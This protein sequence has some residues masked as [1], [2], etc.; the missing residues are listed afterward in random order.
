MLFR[1]TIQAGIVG[2][3]E[4]P[5]LIAS[6]SP[7]F[8]VYTHDRPLFYHLLLSTFPLS[9]KQITHK[10]CLQY[11]ESPLG[12]LKGFKKKRTKKMAF[13][14]NEF[15]LIWQSSHGKAVEKD[16]VVL[17]I[18]N[19]H[20]AR[21]PDTLQTQIN[22]LWTSRKENN[23][24]VRLFNA[25]KFRLA[26][27]TTEDSSLALHIGTTDYKSFVGTHYLD[28]KA[29]RTAIDSNDHDP[30]MSH[31][32][33]IE[34]L[35][36][37]SDGFVVLIRRSEHVAEYPN[38]YCGPG[39]H[40]EPGKVLD[41]TLAQQDCADIAEITKKLQNHSDAVLSELF[42]SPVDEVVDEL[43]VPRDSL[44]LNGL[45]GVA[46]NTRTRGKPDLLFLIRCALSSK[47]VAGIYDKGE[48]AEKFESTR[49]L[50][51]PC[52]DKAELQRM[53]DDD[54]ITPPSAAAVQWLVDTPAE[55][56]G[57]LAA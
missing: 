39:G 15:E 32:L 6:L 31:A 56:L 38:F 41:M 42:A 26:G 27:V 50:C 7:P 36:V 49:L 9:Q 55:L 18:D 52:A 57:S 1:K 35:V 17:V 12:V 14:S 3:R 19:T 10:S 34:S 28:E 48:M 44:T 47:E 45:I 20:D 53:I 13:K 2:Q 11:S 30:F 24:E 46:R 43:G 29:L 5:A 22:A 37:T 4:V 23:P 40:A 54:E 33:G 16:K 21:C 8:S 51:V 25:L